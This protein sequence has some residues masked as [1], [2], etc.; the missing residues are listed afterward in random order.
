MLIGKV[1][2]SVVSTQKD[3]KI[4][5]IESGLKPLQSIPAVSEEDAG[6]RTSGSL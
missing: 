6:K 2:G 1:I 3:E 5:A 4:E